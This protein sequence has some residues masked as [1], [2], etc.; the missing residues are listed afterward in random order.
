MIPA[1]LP[2]GRASTHLERRAIIDR[3]HAAWC[4]MPHQRLGQ[5]IE[6]ACRDKN[7]FYT[8]DTTLAELCEAFVKKENEQ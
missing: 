6:N 3:I 7:I 5:L 8:E 2:I 1:N 4:A